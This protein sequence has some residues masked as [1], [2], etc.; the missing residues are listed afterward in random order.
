[1][2]VVSPNF[3]VEKIYPVFDF[4]QLYEPADYR[5][6]MS[7]SNHIIERPETVVTP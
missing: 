4:V 5:D 2:T 7:E 6:N 1:M 3:L